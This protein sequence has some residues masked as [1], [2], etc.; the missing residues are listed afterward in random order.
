[1]DWLLSSGAL[2]RCMTVNRL[3]E[4]V[5][6]SPRELLNHY[7][8]NPDGKVFAI[9]NLQGMV[10]AI[11]ARYSRAETGLKDTLL[12]EFV[13]EDQLKVNK[14]YKLIERVLI[15]Y[16]DDSIGELEGA[17]LSFENISMLATKV[18]EHR[19]IGG[20]PIEQSTRYVRYDR[21]DPDTDAYYYY[22]PKDLPPAHAQH[23]R[24]SMD[25]LFDRYAA[26]WQPLIDHLEKM[27]PLEAAEYDVGDGRHWSDMKTDKQ[28]RA[29]QRTYQMDMKTKAC[30]ILRGFLPLAT[31]ANV[32]LF[33]NGRYYQHL[34]SKL[35]TSPMAEAQELGDMALAELSKV[36]PNY[37]KRAK[38]MDYVAA[39]ESAMAALATR[40]F[41]DLNPAAEAK[42]WLVEP[43]HPFLAS[44]LN[45]GPVNAEA[46]RRAFIE[47]QELSFDA[48]LV[49][50]YSR[51]SFH[52]IRERLKSLDDTVRKT[53]RDTYY[54]D[55]QVRRNRPERAIE[56]GYPYHFDLVTEWAVYKD[57]MRHRM[58]TIQVQPMR[59]DLGFEMPPEIGD[60][61]LL[62]TAEATVRIAQDL[63]AYLEREFPAAREYAM[64]QGHRMRWLLGMNDRAL[65]HMLELRTAPQ[66][67]VNYRQCCQLL[68]R[69]IKQ[70]FPDRA[71]RMNHVNH[72]ASYWARSD[73]EAKQRRKEAALDED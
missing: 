54:G 61:G 37:V 62:E 24:A 73:S 26:M 67:H 13:K 38:R 4:V 50:A 29:F 25:R 22:V 2:L 53:I 55:R 33:G 48:A 47:E 17:H 69:L 36:I 44:T 63:F 72:D 70:R 6:V 71:M 8:T 59:P 32:G 51:G 65:M 43:D 31:T 42:T 7:V 1:M 15:A 20:S 30:D 5:P 3:V 28:R 45:K 64:L 14:A 11:M 60:A 19:R 52:L 34:I 35:L 49:Y 12:R 40:Y 66:G 58:G 21:R 16:G 23:F 56:H 39:N 57:L 68:H 10:G 18:I 9:Q 46:V 41:G 27:K